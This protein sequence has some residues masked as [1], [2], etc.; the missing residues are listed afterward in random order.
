MGRAGSSGGRSR[1]C[2]EAEG[3][4]RNPEAP[5]RAPGAPGLLR[6]LRSLAMTRV[7]DVNWTGRA[8]LAPFVIARRP[9][10]D[11]AI[12]ARLERRVALHSSLRQARYD[13]A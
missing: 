8:A 2:E 13:A 9:K 5:E 12:S 11:E 4:R 7:I 10:A 1:H 6:E 3:R